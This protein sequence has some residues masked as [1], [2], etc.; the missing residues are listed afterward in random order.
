M[1]RVILLSGALVFALDRKGIA[2]RF[3]GKSA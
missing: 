2:K 3:L 1:I